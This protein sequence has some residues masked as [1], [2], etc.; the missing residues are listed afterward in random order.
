MVFCFVQNFFFG[1]HKSQNSFFC[2][3]EREFFFQNV[4][5]VYMTK[6]LNHIIYFTT[7]FIFDICSIHYLHFVNYLEV[8]HIIFC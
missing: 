3:A 8:G 7:C 1:Q 5:L 6:T 2:L 4:T